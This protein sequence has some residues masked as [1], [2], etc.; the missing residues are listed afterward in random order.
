M[1][2]RFQS[3]LRGT[4]IASPELFLPVFLLFT[5]KVTALVSGPRTLIL[6]LLSTGILVIYSYRVL[7]EN[8]WLVRLGW[9]PPRQHFWFWSIVAGFVACVAVWVVARLF[10]EPL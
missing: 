10:H 6:A 2:G 3:K 1:L 5:W 4:I 8:A 9:S 7:G